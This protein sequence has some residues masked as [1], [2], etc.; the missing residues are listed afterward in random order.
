MLHSDADANGLFDVGMHNMHVQMQ[1]PQCEVHCMWRA[2]TLPVIFSRQYCL[3][4]TGK[5]KVT[6]GTPTFHLTTPAL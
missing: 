3:L 5:T 1:V 2:Q 4:V 6:A